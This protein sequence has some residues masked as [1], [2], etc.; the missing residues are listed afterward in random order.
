MDTIQQAELIGVPW[1]GVYSM[2][3]LRNVSRSLDNIH[4][5]LLNC[6]VCLGDDNGNNSLLA[7]SLGGFY[8]FESVRGHLRVTPTGCLECVWYALCGCDGYLHLLEK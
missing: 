2:E 8:L 7:P 5:R 4:S 1:A 6:M 3:W